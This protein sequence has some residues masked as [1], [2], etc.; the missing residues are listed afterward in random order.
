[1]VVNLVGRSL[2]SR[3]A[4][5]GYCPRVRRLGDKISPRSRVYLPLRT[6][7]RLKDAEAPENILS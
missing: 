2:V 3:T 5:G 4:L 7:P 6:N 1:M